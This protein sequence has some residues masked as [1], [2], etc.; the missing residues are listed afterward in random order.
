MRIRKL[1]ISLKDNVQVKI[2]PPTPGGF[3][4]PSPMNFG[5]LFFCCQSSHLGTMEPETVFL[6]DVLEQMRTLNE[7]GRAVP[8]SISFRTLNRQSKTGGRLVQYPEAKLVIKE[9]NPKAD[10]ITSLR[11]HKKQVKTRRKPNHW[12]NKTR[13]IKLPNGQIKKIHI[14]HIISFNGKKV[15]Y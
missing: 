12:D 3:F 7:N 4:M 10:S 2:K 13:N 9:E 1:R 14:N 15:V 6:R 11:Y 5:V 8:F